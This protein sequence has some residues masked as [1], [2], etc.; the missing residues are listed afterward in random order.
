M[1]MLEPLMHFAWVL[2]LFFHYEAIKNLKLKNFILAGLFLGLALNSK[3][4]SVILIPFT[5]LFIPYH[6][7]NQKMSLKKIAVN[8]LAMYGVGAISVAATYLDAFK[9]IGEKQT[10]INVIS[11]I[12]DS[13]LSKSQSGKNHLINGVVYTKSP[14]WSYLF[15][16]YVQ[17]GVLR[18]AAYIIGAIYALLNRSFFV[19]YWAIFFFMTLAFLQMSG[20]KNERY[21]SSF[22]IPLIVLA[23]SGF[24]LLNKKL[25]YF[26][27]AF[28]ALLGFFIITH[29]SYVVTQ[30][31]TEYNAL[32]S[33][34]LEQKT[35][36]YTTNDKVYIYGSTRSS[37]WY[38]HGK[39]F[40]MF[41]ISKDFQTYCP[42]FNEFTYFIFE[43]DELARYG[44]NLLYE[45]VNQNRDNFVLEEKFGF[46]IFNKIPSRTFKGVCND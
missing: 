45:Y 2:F 43:K 6:F 37:R 41:E 4:T 3:I 14:S 27:Y 10:V 40:A 39:G 28:A 11:G 16:M 22:E 12:K 36:N 30:P 32:F 35:N 15:F 21:V 25:K 26:K 24:Y 1:L 9:K 31:K 29:I 13:Y 33:E 34:Y 20:V 44:S 46:L 38:K 8:Y 5:L 17:E 18:P 42:R 7:F 23:V 19:S